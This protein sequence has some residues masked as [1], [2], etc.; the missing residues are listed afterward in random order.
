MRNGRSL[1]F[2]GIQWVATL[3]RS[4]TSGQ[5]ARLRKIGCSGAAGASSGRSIHPLC[6]HCRLLGLAEPD[7]RQ[8]QRHVTR[9]SASSTHSGA[10]SHPAFSVKV[11]LWRGFT[12]VAAPP[13]LDARHRV[14]PELARRQHPPRAGDDAVRAVDQDRVR[15]ARRD[16]RDLLV[17]MRPCVA[18]VG[19]CSAPGRYAMANFTPRPLS[20]ARPAYAISRLCTE[21]A[22]PVGAPNDGEIEDAPP[23][24]RWLAFNANRFEASSRIRSASSAF[25]NRRAGSA[26]CAETGCNRRSDALGRTAR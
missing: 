18:R 9:R 1:V 23:R 13:E 19:I 7:Q 4:V 25:Q 21:T 26:W 5:I 11:L 2:K 17:R 6:Q 8:I 3:R 15:P 20:N 16:L 10:S 14:D 12:P 22:A 24:R